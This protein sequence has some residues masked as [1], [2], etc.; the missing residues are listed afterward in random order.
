MPKTQDLNNHGLSIKREMCTFFSET[1]VI[2]RDEEEMELECVSKAT[3]DGKEYDFTKSR[4]GK[5]YFLDGRLYSAPEDARYHD[6]VI[7]QEVTENQQ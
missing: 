3:I 2:D 1:E 6:Y 5:A 4:E 7:A